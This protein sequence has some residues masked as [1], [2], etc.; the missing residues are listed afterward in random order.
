MIEN[1]IYHT[2]CKSPA[3]YYDET[4]RFGRTTRTRQRAGRCYAQYHIRP[5]AI[6]T[7]S[8]AY[9]LHS[10]LEDSTPHVFGETQRP[11]V[12]HGRSRPTKGGKQRS[13]LL[14]THAQQRS[15]PT[16]ECDVAIYTIMRP[17]A[18]AVLL[19]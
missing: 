13:R 11:R 10:H 2:M 14:H 3:G 5:D 17:E 6:Y 8:I 7:A 19:C 4:T 1:N 18:H 12:A 15:G 9:L 16:P